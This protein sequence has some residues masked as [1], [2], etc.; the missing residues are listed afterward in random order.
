MEGGCLK[1]SDALCRPYKRRKAERG[2]WET[3]SA[4]RSDSIPVDQPSSYGN[5]LI[6]DVEME[7]VPSRTSDLT[8]PSLCLLSQ[9]G[10][11]PE[12]VLF[13]RAL[14]AS[15][16][17]PIR[18]SEPGDLLVLW[19]RCCRFR[20]RVDCPRWPSPL[21]GLS[22]VAALPCK[23]PLC[24]FCLALTAALPAKGSAHVDSGHGASVLQ[25]IAWFRS[26][27]ISCTCSVRRQA[28]LTA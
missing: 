27:A 17:V 2:W 1:C 10:F 6:L 16:I 24:S 25:T 18:V 5:T 19:S 3:T 22:Y 4:D 20:K 28:V 23:S 12:P 8:G 11:S 13:R 14:G 21:I 7:S 9:F 15:S 26:L